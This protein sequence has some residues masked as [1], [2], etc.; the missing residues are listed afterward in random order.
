MDFRLSWTSFRQYDGS[1]RTNDKRHWTAKRG[2]P[3]R[4]RPGC[5][6]RSIQSTRSTW[7]LSNELSFSRKRKKHADGANRILRGSRRRS[8]TRNQ[9]RSKH[10]HGLTGPVPRTSPPPRLK[11]GRKQKETR[12]GKAKKEKKN[13]KES[14]ETT[15]PRRS[16]ASTSHTVVSHRYRYDCSWEGQHVQ[17]RQR[18]DRPAWARRTTPPVWD[19]DDDSWEYVTKKKPSVKRAVLYVG[20]LDPETTEDRLHEFISRRAAKVQIKKPTIFTCKIFLKEDGEKTCGARITVDAEAQQHLEWDNSGQVGCTHGSGISRRR[21]NRQRTK[22]AK[23]Q[24]PNWPKEKLLS[25]GKPENLV[26]LR[27]RNS[28]RHNDAPGESMLNYHSYEKI[29]KET[30]KYL[31]PECKKS[32]K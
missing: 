28:C 31:P 9:V 7:K 23:K 21:Y 6:R 4:L 26:L 19:S 17:A 16:L 20:N 12:T 18:D 14:K 10:N 1:W 15:F 32:K 27:W 22:N 13:E 11:A 2:C 3:A 30:F 29:L 8:Q 25:S 24:R 5:R